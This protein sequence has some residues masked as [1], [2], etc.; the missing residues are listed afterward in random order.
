MYS[1]LAIVATAA[2]ALFAAAAPAPNA[3]QYT[4]STGPVKCCNSMYKPGSE[5]HS[6]IEGL[7]GLKTGDILSNIFTN[8]SPL[9][10]VLGG[11][12]SGQTVCCNKVSDNGLVNFNCNNVKL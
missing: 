5:E 4:C 12:C 8:C 7:L 3:P 10:D 1:K 9:V 11:G 2:F 6:F